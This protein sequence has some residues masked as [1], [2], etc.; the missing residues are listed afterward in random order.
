MSVRREHAGRDEAEVHQATATVLSSRDDPEPVAAPR[1]GSFRVSTLLMQDALPADAVS[2]GSGLRNQE[3]LFS[4]PFKEAREE[5]L[6]I[7]AANKLTYLCRSDASDTGWLQQ[8]VDVPGTFTEVVAAVHP[9]GDVWAFCVP[10][11]TG[12]GYGV[13]QAFKLTESGSGGNSWVLQADG[14]A[15][16]WRARSLCVSYSPDAGPL[17]LGLA[18]GGG[19]GMSMYLTAISAQLPV[20]GVATGPSPWVVAVSVITDLASDASLVGG[21]FLPY[22][23]TLGKDRIY[24]FYLQ[25]GTALARRTVGPDGHVTTVNCGT[26]V[27]RFCGS[28]NV[29]NFPQSGP[30]G[31][32]GFIYLDSGNGDLV[33]GY[34][35]SYNGGSPPFVSRTSALD[36]DSATSWQDA[37]G[38]IHV[39]GTT[40]AGTLRVLHQASWSTGPASGNSAAPVLP[41]WTQANLEYPLPGGIGGYDLAWPQDRVFA[42]DWDSTGHADHLVCYRARTEDPVLRVLQKN[43]D[44]SFKMVFNSRQQTLQYSLAAGDQ[45][46]AFDYDGSGCLDHLVVYRPGAGMIS[47]LKRNKQQTG[48]TFTTVVA[49]AKGGIGGFDLGDASDRMFAFVYDDA[50]KLLNHLVAYQPGTGI[51]YIL[52]KAS[53]GTGADSF[54][55]VYHQGKPGDPGLGAAGIGG[56]NLR[57]SRDVLFAYDYDGTGRRD[58]IVC[59]RPGTG[60][61][62]IVKKVSNNDDRNAFT[63]V[64]AQ[65]GGIGGYPVNDGSDRL[66]AYGYRSSAAP[67]GQPDHLV[68]FRPGTG[69]VWVLKKVSDDDKPEAFQEVFRSGDAA[70]NTPGDGIGGYDL[71]NPADQLSTFDYAG[72]GKGDDL[73]LYR[74]GGGNIWILR[75][76]GDLF[77]PVYQ[78]PSTSTIVTVGLQAQIASFQLDP[79]PDY[80]PSELVKLTGPGVTAAEAYCIST[81]DVTTSGWVTDK[82]RRGPLPEDET[83]TDVLHMVSHYVADV[84]LLDTG[85]RPLPARSVNVAADSLVEVQVGAVSYQ[86]GPGRTAEVKTNNMGKL[87]VSVA[88]RGLSVPVI[89]LNT[90]GLASGAAIDFAAQVNDYLAGGSPLPSQKGT[91]TADALQGAQCTD[92]AGNTTPLVADWTKSPATPA[93]TVKHCTDLYGMAVGRKPQLA[94]V[95]DG[96]AGPQ[97]IA[98]YVIQKWDSSRPSYQVFRTQDELDAY[99]AYRDNHPAYAGFWDDFQTWATDVWEG[100]KS[101]A[102]AVAEVFVETVVEIAVWV[103]NAVVS[104]GKMIINGIEQAVQAVEAVFQMIADAVSRVI[105]WL[106]SLF[107]F[108]DIWETKKALESGLTTILDYGVRTLEHYGAEAHGWFETQ[109]AAV[110][111]LFTDLKARYGDNAVGDFQ[112]RA[113][114]LQD[115]GGNQVDRASVTDNP[116][117][118]WMLNQAHGSIT[119]YLR[120]GNELTFDL[121]DSPIE[122]KFKD[123]TTALANSGVLADLARAGADFGQA[124]ESLFNPDE[125]PSASLVALL[126]MLEHL[127]LAVLKA[128]DAVVTGTVTLASVFVQGLSDFLKTDVGVPFLDTLYCWIQETGKV[129]EHER[130]PTL[131]YG[132]FVFLAL[133]FFTTVIYKLINGIDNPPFPGGEFPAVPAPPWHPSYDAQAEPVMPSEVALPLQITS[134]SVAVLGTVLSLYGDICGITEA[135]PK[136]PGFGDYQLM[137]LLAFGSA[138]CDVWTWMV[139]N[140]PPVGGAD[141]NNV[142]YSGAF[143]AG[144]AITLLEYAA[145][146]DFARSD[147]LQRKNNAAFLRLRKI[148]NSP[149]GAILSSILGGTALGFEIA[150]CVT[151]N[152][153]PYTT[154]QLVM[155]MLPDCIQIF[156]VLMLP[157]PLQAKYG[158]AAGI[159]AADGLLNSANLVMGLVAASYENLHKPAIDACTLPSATAGIDYT[160]GGTDVTAL[161][162]T[163]ADMPWNGPISNWKPAT[164]TVLPAGLSL[165]QDPANPKKCFIV[166][167]PQ[168]PGQYE[169][170]VVCSDGYGPPVYSPAQ[171]MPL[172]VAACPVTTLALPAGQPATMNVYV[173]T[174]NNPYGVNPQ[175]Q[176]LA[177]DGTGAPVPYAQILFS[178]PTAPAGTAIATATF[179]LS[180]APGGPLGGLSVAPAYTD[181]NGLA[182][183]PPFTA[184][185]V[186]GSYNLTAAIAGAAVA[187][188]T[189]AVITNNATNVTALTAAT[190]STGQSAYAGS[191]GRPGTQFPNQLIAIAQAGTTPVPNVVIVFS[192]PPA[193]PVHGSYGVFA[194]NN[195]GT[196]VV[197][198]DANGQANAGQFSGARVNTFGPGFPLPL[199]F[200]VTAQISGL[201]T[202]QAAF[203]LT[204]VKPPGNLPPV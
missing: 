175:I 47:I 123:I 85:G 28:W 154:A 33:T 105:D 14:I 178:F 121:P 34:C 88:A 30:Q 114:Q 117:A 149:L 82:V 84:T 193:D 176:V 113:P 38:K 155:G 10:P 104:L 102:T 1:P 192:A 156:R 170:S 138:T 110:T 127:A 166:G 184:N 109:E 92:S 188:I 2:V 128:L 112:N 41:V 22:S 35:A 200:N 51:V 116:Q 55:P 96:Y 204:Y 143:A 75:P 8:P 19:G 132:S 120:A 165:K 140:A 76:D 25:T 58:H 48:D 152:S 186:T 122:D 181:S 124:I 203:A 119:S 147:A 4:N 42:F 45:M 174:T 197:V 50:G 106:K 194:N 57:D 74:P 80:K 195:S 196:I 18:G 129:P 46:F 125:G 83:S 13:V 62:W 44:G 93:E 12:S 161:T 133:G 153:D 40:P 64:Y 179:V 32:V 107:A 16:G 168:T 72:T 183:V 131:K 159:A 63:S 157:L 141:W 160:K 23:P 24:V 20:S 3:A 49:V 199:N 79:Y 171:T 56:Y 59:Y 43:P 202:P 187:P 95:L 100:I 135:D 115:S 9:N 60:T 61:V 108:K 164:G 167:A 111:A 53:G 7:D 29:P 67:G 86:V 78:A 191:P 169:V 144:S 37:D 11:L 26:T 5:A 77:V 180:G 137:A 17:I 90:D 177:T 185:G 198:T 70:G 145:V 139:L 173:S 118:G 172:T 163:G 71:A 52:K 91:L 190:T 182:T 69:I 136:F 54:Q 151:T 101:G 27:G 15:G 146:I 98:G 73:V 66:L 39:F 97:P 130:E 103:G 21:G 36:F 81:Q 89:Y 65:G 150:G 6:V 126:D 189:A 162:A 99:R 148:N 142:G 68:A 94:A 158:V 134:Y 87:S 31:D 201:A